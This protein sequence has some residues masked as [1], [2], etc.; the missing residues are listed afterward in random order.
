MVCGE[1]A[2]LGSTRWETRGPQI[3]RSLVRSLPPERAATISRRKPP[4]TIAETLEI[5]EDFGARVRQGREKMELSHEELGRRI[6]EKVSLLRKIE[7]GRMVPDHRLANKLEHSLQ[8]KLL[9]PVSEPEVSS[10]G[11][12]PP[13]EVTLGER[14][15][16]RRKKMEVSEERK[17]S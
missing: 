1:C 17:P 8:V 5:V 4:T 12:P 6:G 14:V 2:K 16:L 7:S 9:V 10:V 15:R 13:R 11:M 3:R